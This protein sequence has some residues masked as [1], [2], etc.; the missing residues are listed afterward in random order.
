[1]NDPSQSMAI[2]LPDVLSFADGRAVRNAAEWPARRHELLAVA[3]TLV[4]GVLPPAPE[5]VGCMELH[6]ATL[7]HLRSARLGSYRVSADGHHAF[8]MQVYAPEGEGPFPV[9]VNGD[10]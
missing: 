5:A 8:L 1:M 4:Y 7:R 3:L 6:V 2:T 10:A 9:I